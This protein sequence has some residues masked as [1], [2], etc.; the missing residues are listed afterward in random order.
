M[1]AADNLIVLLTAELQKAQ[2]ALQMMLSYH[3][4]GAADYADAAQHR[5]QE[6]LDSLSPVLEA[7]RK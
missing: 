7:L 5:A 6:A 4:Q 1:S 3:G 2:L